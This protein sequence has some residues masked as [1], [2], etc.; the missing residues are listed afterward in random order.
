MKF[1]F[2]SIKKFGSNIQKISKQRYNDFFNPEHDWVRGLAGVTI[3]F[4]GGIVYTISQFYLQWGIPNEIAVDDTEVLNYR[5]QDVIYFANQYTEKEKIFNEL[6][7]KQYEAP[8]V[9]LP[10]PTIIESIPDE[11]RKDEPLAEDIVSQ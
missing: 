4:I 7:T 6:R 3:M 10:E 11:Q 9:T 2:N 5:E 8:L 1:N